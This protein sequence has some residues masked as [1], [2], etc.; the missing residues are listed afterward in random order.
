M[1]ST[2]S[3]LQFGKLDKARSIAIKVCVCAWN[4]EFLTFG[5]FHFCSVDWICGTSE[6][7]GHNFEG[8]HLCQKGIILVRI[9]SPYASVCLT[10]IYHQLDHPG[11]I[12]LLNAYF[13]VSLPPFSVSTVSEPILLSDGG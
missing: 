7:S 12:K 1:N 3:T 13:V 10:G 9:G 5:C 11:I 4:P 8:D 2:W 6:E